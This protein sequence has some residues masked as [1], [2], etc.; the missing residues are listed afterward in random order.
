MATADPAGRLSARPRAARVLRGLLVSA[1]TAATGWLLWHVAASLR[2]VRTA[3]WDVG[4]A[5]GLTSY[6]LLVVLVS[7]GL[8]L[9]HP[10]SPGLGRLAPLTR[11]RLHATLA[12]FTLAFTLLHVVALSTDPWAHV[13]W[14]GA[15]LPMASQYRPV[16]VTLGVLA[17]WSGLVT[18][19]TA[20]LAGR[21]LGR[22]WWPVHKV[23]GLA[24]LLAWVHGVLAGSDSRTLLVGYGASGGAV[25]ALALSRYQARSAADLRDEP[26]LVELPGTGTPAASGAGEDL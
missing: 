15:L 2:G 23:A 10:A 1:S 16:G 26:A 17:V 11:M 14:Q 9:S 12:V 8:V 7:V 5:G 20:A 18:G 4:R 3:P 21:A 25:L 13:G 22:V 19:V 6:G 24:F